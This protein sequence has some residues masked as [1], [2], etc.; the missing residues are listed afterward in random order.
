M[1]ETETGV[2]YLPR[3]TTAVMKH[4]SDKNGNG[5]CESKESPDL[6]KRSSITVTSLGLKEDVRTARSQQCDD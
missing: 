3:G 5:S 2:S 4:R 1:D 6:L